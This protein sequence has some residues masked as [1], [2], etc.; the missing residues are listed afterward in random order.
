MGTPDYNS[1][2]AAVGTGPYRLVEYVPSDRAVFARNPAWWG[3]P[4]PWDRV[5]YRM[6]PNNSARIAALK[7]GDVDVIDAVPTHDV[8]SLKTNAKLT[9]ASK[10]GVRNI[11]LYADQR[12]D[13]T[14]FVLDAD[15]NNPSANPLKDRRVRQALSLAIN[16]SAIVERVMSGQAA[17]SGQFLPEGTM[18]WNP[19][20]APAPYDP[21]RAKKL[22]AEAG[23][24]RGFRLTLHGPNDRYVND[25][26]IVQAIAQMW[27]R[28]G[29]Q[30]AVELMPANVYFT[31][32]A[33]DEFSVGLMG[34]GTGTGEPDSPLAALVGTADKAKGRGVTNRSLY[35]NPELDGLIDA[36]LGTI[37]AAEREALYRRATAVAMEDLAII[38]LHHQVNIWA[39]RSGFAYNARN[40]ER[41]MAME[42][43][44]VP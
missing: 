24:P 20:L 35:S 13:Q 22:L 36:A 31:R 11:Y 21:E 17:A 33:K 12:R 7:A 1:G 5:V 27:T 32:S 41:T 26:Q 34:W 23:F 43:R 6:I 42:L 37:D 19:D 44:P 3:P 15:G 2:K 18:G 14:P 28:V 25:G 30:T 4:Q 8:E 39:M 38:P 16:R 9:L 40:D 10:A 29:V